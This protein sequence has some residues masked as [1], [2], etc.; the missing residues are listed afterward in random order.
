MSIKQA[1]D[2]NQNPEW[3]GQIQAGPVGR[4]SNRKPYF[5]DWSITDSGIILPK[6]L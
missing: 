6:S 4:M 2:I 1:G 5:N 3:P